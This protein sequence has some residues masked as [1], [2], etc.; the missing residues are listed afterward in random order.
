MS[1]DQAE[2]IIALLRDL[3]EE[4]RTVRSTLDDFTGLGTYKVSDLAEA[5]TGPLGYHLGDVHSKLDDVLTGLSSVESAIDL[6]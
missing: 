6:K 5:L 2:E 3:L 4:T 1:N